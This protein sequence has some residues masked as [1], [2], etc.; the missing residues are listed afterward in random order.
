MGMLGFG[1]LSCLV[2]PTIKKFYPTNPKINHIT[3]NKE[4]MGGGVN[5]IFWWVG[6][7]FLV[8]GGVGQ[9]KL[10]I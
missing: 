9:K 1:G 5:V 6:K 3:V 7:V 4:K 2:K 10:I 8:D